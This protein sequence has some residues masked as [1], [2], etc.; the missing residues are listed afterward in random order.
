MPGT[1]H[2]FPLTVSAVI[3]AASA[4]L[5]SACGDDE[6]ADAEGGSPQP[7]AETA[8]ETAAAPGEAEET[9][10]DDEQQDPEP[11]SEEE[12]MDILLTSGELPE[13]P[14]GHSTHT[15]LGWFDEELAVESGA[16]ADAFGESECAAALDT[17]NVS[18]VGED[19]QAGVAH[20][21]RRTLDDEDAEE[22]PMETL[23]VWALAYPEESPSQT[24]ELWEDLTAACSDGLDLRDE[25][26]DVAPLETDD[27]YPFNGMSLTIT[28]GDE[29]DGASRVEVYSATADV[30]PNTIML[31]AVNMDQETFTDLLDIQSEKLEEHLENA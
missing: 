12:M 29:E 21:Y 27:D 7:T 25:E 10:E 4:L 16:Y 5:L 1:A 3:A 17:V 9:A 24:S 6:N 31:S 2:S 14:T 30:G 20:E 22:G 11:L 8:E 18:L 15:G 28:M 26:I 23:V 19:A 13:T